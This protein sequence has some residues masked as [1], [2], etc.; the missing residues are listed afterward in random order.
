VG[1]VERDFDK[2]VISFLDTNGDVGAERKQDLNRS[3]ELLSIDN[4]GTA[5][6]L[7]DSVSDKPQPDSKSEKKSLSETSETSFNLGLRLSSNPNGT[8]EFSWSNREGM[9]YSLLS[10]PTLDSDP[11]LWSVHAGDNGP[12]A[13]IAYNGKTENTITGI[14]VSG[15]PR[16]FSILEEPIINSPPAVLAAT[17]APTNPTT[18]DDIQ[19]T[20]TDYID[21]DGDSVTFSYEWKINGTTVPSTTTNSLPASETV[22]GDT[23]Q[24]FILPFDG[25]NQGQ[26]FSTAEVTVSD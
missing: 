10:S 6:R 24:C 3:I 19:V 18:T 4:D 11:S 21:A 13:D 1:S 2:A 15:S 14:E 16:F 7:D 5:Q 20:I 12:Y 9:V 23:V 22:A 17:I 26:S 8:F 25:Q